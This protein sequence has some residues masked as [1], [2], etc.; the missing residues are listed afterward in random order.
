[1]ML[2]KQSGKFTGWI[3]YSLGRALRNF[4]NPDYH[5]WYPANHERIHELN[6]VASYKYRRWDFSGV[7]IY[8][9]GLP[10]TAPKSYYLSSGH[11]VA[12]FGEHNA[13]RLRP[14][15]RLDLSATFNI[16]KTEK[17]ENGINLSI[18]NALARE[19]DIMYKLKVYPEE[20]FF[21]YGRQSFMLRIIPSISYHHKF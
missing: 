17:Y 4:D 9:T 19:N 16:R 1:M 11:I 5:G 3:S 2:H 15:I 13:C 21:R 18:V 20:G 14:Y 8:A 10:F 7:F 12:E 6:A